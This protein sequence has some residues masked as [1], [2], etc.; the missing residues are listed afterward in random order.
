MVRVIV[1]F[2]EFAV[3]RASARARMKL[4]SVDGAEI[5]LS[6]QEINTAAA[7]RRTGRLAQ[8]KYLRMH[9]SLTESA[10]P[11]VS[12]LSPPDEVYDPRRLSL[13]PTLNSVT[14]RT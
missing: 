14:L 5:V 13:E 3:S 1:I 2:S 8:P 4:S 6:P 7:Q 12:M 9:L 10:F 11:D